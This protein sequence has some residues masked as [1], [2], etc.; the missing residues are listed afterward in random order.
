ML[1]SVA[2]ACGK[3]PKQIRDAFKE[4]GDLG[5]VV[6]QGKKE[7]NTLGSFFGAAKTAA[8][9]PALLFKDVFARF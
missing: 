6:F 5:A 8:K 1:K 7:Q 9:K 2:K 3:T 4:E